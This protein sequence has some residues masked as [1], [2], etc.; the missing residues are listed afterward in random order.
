MYVC[1]G[2]ALIEALILKKKQKQKLKLLANSNKLKVKNKN[3]ILINYKLNQ[4]KHLK[5]VRCMKKERKNDQIELVC[6]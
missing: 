3:K 6:M 2:E 5:L 1:V 4:I